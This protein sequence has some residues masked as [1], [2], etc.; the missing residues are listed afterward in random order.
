MKPNKFIFLL[1]AII[2]FCGIVMYTFSPYMPPSPRYTANS[3]VCKIGDPCFITDIND[4]ISIAAFNMQ[5]FGQSK[6]SNDT[7]LN[8]YAD[9]INDYTI[10]FLSEVRDE[11]GE[12]VKKLCS[13]SL[14]ENYTCF[15]SSRAGLTSSK[16]N[17]FLVYH[18][19]NNIKL[20]KTI[21]YNIG[22]NNVM[23]YVSQRPPLM[24]LFN[25]NGK[26]YRFY[27]MHTSPSSVP[28]DLALLENITAPYKAEN[29]SNT[30]ILGDLNLACD[31]A[32]GQADGY[33]KDWIWNIKDT[34]DTTVGASSCAYDRVISNFQPREVGIYKNI[35][36]D[37]SDHYLVWIKL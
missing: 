25:I 23:P 33:F 2:V 19:A 32:N 21:D 10:T 16:E 5:I 3:S 22:Y 12:A 29:A 11:S 6:A 9:I 14:L 36:K 24:A 8:K 17:Y 27:T 15:T 34:D 13:N 30:I 37:L 35:T 18:N 7:L 26:D 1:M 4:N 20:L 31:Y 28:L